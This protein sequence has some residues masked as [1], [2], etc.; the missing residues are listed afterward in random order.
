MALVLLLPAPL[1]H[2]ASARSAPVRST[3]QN[4]KIYSMFQLV[5]HKVQYK[6]SRPGLFTTL[7]QIGV[8]SSAGR[9]HGRGGTAGQNHSSQSRSPTH[10]SRSPCLS[11]RAFL[12]KSIPDSHSLPQTD[13]A[14]SSF[15]SR[16]QTPTSHFPCFSGARSFWN[17]F[18]DT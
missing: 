18:R 3:A 13:K 16:S 7:G 11:G 10:T 17:A 12:T 15:R 4:R 14:A 6:K 2:A 9:V 1:A 5:S 8:L